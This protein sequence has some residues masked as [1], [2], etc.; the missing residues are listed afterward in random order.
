MC[1]VAYKVYLGK[2]IPATL[3]S[4]IILSQIYVPEIFLKNVFVT[5]EK[6]LNSGPLVNQNPLNSLLI[7]ICK[8]HHMFTYM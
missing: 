6:G 1:I 2:S 7:F 3:K 8:D 5:F 4:V